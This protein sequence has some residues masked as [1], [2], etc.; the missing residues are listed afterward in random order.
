M[1]YKLQGRE[2]VEITGDDWMNLRVDDSV[3]IKRTILH[4]S[5][6]I[7]TVFMSMSGRKDQTG[8]PLVFETMIFGGEHDRYQR[9]YAT[10]DDA[11]RGHQETIEMIFEL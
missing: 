10:Y 3:S 2:V 9:R 11:E 1:Y 6:L 7:S 8:R 5:T 4:D